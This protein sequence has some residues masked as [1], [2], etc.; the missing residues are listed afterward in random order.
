MR[1]GTQPNV[2]ARRLAGA[3]VAALAL[4]S[5]TAMAQSQPQRQPIAPSSSSATPASAGAGAGVMEPGYV[6]SPE[7]VNYRTAYGA[8]WRGG[9]WTPAMAAE[10]CD[11]TARASVPPPPVA[12]AQQPAPQAQPE[13]APAERRVER[14]AERTLRVLRTAGRHEVDRVQGS[15]ARLAE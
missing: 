2:K 12:A 3:V 9:S 4:T 6:N 14:S 11:V 7:G 8:C 5:A 10:P 1:I 15:D 13:P